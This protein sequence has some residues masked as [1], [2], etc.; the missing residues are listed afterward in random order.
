MNRAESQLC[1][2]GVH[3][4]STYVD[5]GGNGVEFGFLGDQS[6]SKCLYYRSVHV[7]DIEAWYMYFLDHEES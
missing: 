4:V 3:I 1:S 2:L 5:C 6:Y 7:I